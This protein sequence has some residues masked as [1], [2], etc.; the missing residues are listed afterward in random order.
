VLLR[1][2]LH[3]VLRILLRF[4]NAPCGPFEV[5]LGGLQVM[6]LRNVGT[7]AQPGGRAWSLDK[8]P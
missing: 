2:L 7:V 1:I 4:P 8:I 5:F 3:F 6:L